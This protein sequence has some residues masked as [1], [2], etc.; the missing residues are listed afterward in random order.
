[1]NKIITPL[2]RCLPGPGPAVSGGFQH[3]AKGGEPVR[4]VRVA[5]RRRW[6]CSACSRSPPASPWRA[7]CRR[8]W[9][10][11]GCPRSPPAASPGRA[12]ARPGAGPGWRL[13]RIA[14]TGS[15]L[16]RRSR[17]RAS[18]AALSGV[19]GLGH[20][21]PARRRGG[22]RPVLRPGAALPQRQARALRRPPPP[23]WRSRSPRSTCSARPPGSPPGSWPAP[24]RVL[25]RPGRRRRSDAGRRAPARPRTTPSRPRW[26]RWPRQ[27]A[28]ALRARGVR[29]VRLRLRHLAVHRP[30]AGAR[31]GRAATSPP[32]TSPRSRRSRWTRAG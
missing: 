32:A 3:F 20:A 16:S 23:S 28:R 31:A 18:N 25:D 29:A 5:R 30:G 12:G 21:R 15:R 4:R 19:L 27:T 8:G 14:Q 6:P 7:C 13:G 1:M 9:R 24:S 26:R 11:G 22:R 17:P 2:P 10:C